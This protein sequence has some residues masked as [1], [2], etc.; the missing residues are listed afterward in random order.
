MVKHIPYNPK[1]YPGGGTGG[2]GESPVVLIPDGWILKKVVAIHEY[3]WVLVCK[4]EEG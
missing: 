2:A 1:L 4:K 3:E